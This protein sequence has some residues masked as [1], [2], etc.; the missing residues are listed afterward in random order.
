MQ[1]SRTAVE[2]DIFAASNIIE[3]SLLVEISVGVKFRFFILL[4]WGPQPPKMTKY[5]SKARPVCPKRP[6]KSCASTSSLI[7]LQTKST[8]SS[9]RI[10]LKTLAAVPPYVM[11][12][13]PRENMSMLILQQGFYPVDKA[14][15]LIKTPLNGVLFEARR[16]VVFLGL[17]ISV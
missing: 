5:L 14:C 8:E 1:R 6:L 13:L 4:L 10:S 7:T 12:L 11:N 3:N 2:F 16:F 15:F 9:E 17:P